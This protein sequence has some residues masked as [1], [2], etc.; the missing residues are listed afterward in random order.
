MCAA[1][2]AAHMDLYLKVFPLFSLEEFVLENGSIFVYEMFLKGGSLIATSMV[3][4]ESPDRM[5][6]Y[7]I[8][9]YYILL[10]C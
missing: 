4:E 9:N 5:L 10:P 6:Y 2:S 3:L 8:T 1:T 7:C